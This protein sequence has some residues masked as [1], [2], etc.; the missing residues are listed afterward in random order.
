MKVCSVCNQISFVDYTGD[1]CGDCGSSDKNQKAQQKK[2]M[3]SIMY[4]ADKLSVGNIMALE[5]LIHELAERKGNE[6]W[7]LHER[8]KR[9]K[10]VRAKNDSENSR[11]QREAG[12]SRRDG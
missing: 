11:A 5:R 8:I 4:A 9:E 3:K 6:I 1:I 2:I 7:D 10:E 12:R